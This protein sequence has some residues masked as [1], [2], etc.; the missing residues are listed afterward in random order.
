VERSVS[1]LRA[2]LSLTAREHIAL[3]GAGGKTTLMFALAEELQRAG[4]RV[5]TSTTTKVWH[6]QAMEAPCVVYA[7]TLQPGMDQLEKG[8]IDFGH[9]FVG[10]C[11]LESG[12]V[13]GVGPAVSDTLFRDVD[14]DY[15][16]VE[17]DGA[18]G[19]PIKAPAAHEPV[20]PASATA[21]VGLM[22]LEAVNRPLSS[23]VAFRLDET[24]HITGLTTGMPLT[25][26][27]LARLFTHPEGVFKGAP[28]AARRIAFLN[29]LDLLD[30]DEDALELAGIILEETKARISS[31]ILGS[32]KLGRYRVME[33]E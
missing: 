6:H 4:K 27:A 25:P 7:D 23:E 19:L 28:R 5:I 20:I 15:L 12:K 22:G 9:V 16:F 2:A 10:R 29:K 33:R 24:K 21:V 1:T 3:V 18:A 32:L 8:L 30:S 11:V 13:D 26:P 17:A 31:V 14:V